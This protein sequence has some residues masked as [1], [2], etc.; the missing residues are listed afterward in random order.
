ML[1]DLFKKNKEKKAGKIVE[2]QVKEQDIPEEYKPYKAYI[3]EMFDFSLLEKRIN[4]V[5][6]FK[7]LEIN[8]N[9][10]TMEVDADFEAMLAAVQKE[11]VT[12]SKNFNPFLQ[13]AFYEEPDV[14]KNQKLQDRLEKLTQYFAKKIQ[15]IVLANLPTPEMMKFVHSTLKKQ[16]ARIEIVANAKYDILTNYTLEKIINPEPKTKREKRLARKKE[17]EE[18]GEPALPKNTSAIETLALW[19]QGKTIEEISEMR[20]IAVNSI[21]RHLG[22]FII[23]GE[24][25]ARELIPPEKMYKL[26]EFFAA[27][28]TKNF[29]YA[30]AVLGGEFNYREMRF[31]LCHLTYLG[32]DK[33]K[34][35]KEIRKKQEAEAAI[36]R[37]A[38]KEKRQIEHQE[39]MIEDAKRR[40]KKE[41]LKLARLQAEEAR[42]KAAE[43]KLWKNIRFD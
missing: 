26:I 6:F 40:E 22:Q 37:Q 42:K 3:K 28:T 14:A 43:A 17:R 12:L 31:A 5:V 16:I 25:S 39:R 23:K 2:E 38:E 18:C 8:A 20:G 15:K 10:P 41:A 34:E 19:R 36:A 32:K 30:M 13:L 11:I 27:N 21:E 24:I 1:K 7:R 35:Q 29:A 4:A 9:N 33:K